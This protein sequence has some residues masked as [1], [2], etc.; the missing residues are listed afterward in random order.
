MKKLRKQVDIQRADEELLPKL[1][2]LA[3]SRCTVRGMPSW[4]NGAAPKIGDSAYVRARG[5]CRRGLVVAVARTRA[6]VAY[7]TTS[8]PTR[9]HRK[10]DRFDELVAG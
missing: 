2:P 9:V 1:R 8:N 5:M 4:D 10:A 7:V 3:D 6:T